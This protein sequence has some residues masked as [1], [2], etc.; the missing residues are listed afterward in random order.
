MIPACWS[1]C[2]YVIPFPWVLDGPSNSLLMKRIQ[3]KW[4]DVVL[5][6]GDKKPVAFLLGILSGSPTY[7]L[8]LRKVSCPVVSCSMES[9][10]GKGLLPLA[11]SQWGPK[12]CH[13]QCA[14]AWMQILPQS[15]LEMTT[16]MTDTLTAAFGE[17]LRQG[18]L[19]SCTRNPDSQTPWDNK[20]LVF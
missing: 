7:P 1:S 5:S 13:Q 20:C 9:P 19:P 3:Q 8:A 16:A 2:A 10:C 4:W 15:S 11:S 18:S 14:W 6:L 17:T 12:P